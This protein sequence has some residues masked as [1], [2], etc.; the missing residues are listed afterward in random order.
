M[1]RARCLRRNVQIP[2]CGEVTWAAPSC[3]EEKNEPPPLAKQAEAGGPPVENNIAPDP[4]ASAPHTLDFTKPQNRFSKMIQEMER[5]YATARPLAKRVGPSASRSKEPKKSRKQGDE[6]VAPTDEMGAASGTHEQ[7]DEDNADD[8]ED[9]DDNDSRSQSNESWYDMEDDFIDDSELLDEGV[10]LSRTR[11]A[12]CAPRAL[13]NIELS[14]N[15]VDWTCTIR[16]APRRCWRRTMR[17]RLRR[18]G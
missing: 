15:A 17:S 4:T 12:A 7:N 3:D 6:S 1:L 18:G 9:A 2:E 8:N 10:R 16:V 11:T 5:K 13:P 14:P